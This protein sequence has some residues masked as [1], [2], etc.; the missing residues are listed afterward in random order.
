[1]ASMRGVL[2]GSAPVSDARDVRFRPTGMSR[3]GEKRYP[4]G[5]GEA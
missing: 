4:A 5:L 3:P 2:L 1:M